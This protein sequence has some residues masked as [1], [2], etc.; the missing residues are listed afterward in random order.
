MLIQAKQEVF[1]IEAY[2]LL[3]ICLLHVKI[4][5]FGLFQNLLASSLSSARTRERISWWLAQVL[6][7]A[8]VSLWP[9]HAVGWR[10]T[11]EQMALNSS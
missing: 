7:H 2:I 10:Q 3:P 4:K 11:Q 5:P 1:S 6:F 8:R 9:Q